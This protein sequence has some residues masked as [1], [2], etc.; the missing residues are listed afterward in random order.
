MRQ[1]FG[2][3]RGVG[4]G[5]EGGIVE[6]G[7]NVGVGDGGTVDGVTFSMATGAVAL[8]SSGCSWLTILTPATALVP[9]EV[10]VKRINRNFEKRFSDID[11]M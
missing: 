1:E 4:V 7:L 10:V 8:A 11:R 6:V 2:L 3:G 5:V 9:R